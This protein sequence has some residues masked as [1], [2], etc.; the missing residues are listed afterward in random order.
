[1]ER[2]PW[3]ERLNEALAGQGL[4]VGVRSRFLE[5]L[6]DHLEDLTDGG[7]KMMSG[8]EV[9]LRMGAPEELA[10]RAALEHRRSSW[11]RRHPRLVFLAAPIPATLV[12]MAAYLLVAGLMAFGITEAGL[13][14]AD[15][16]SMWETP[17]SVFVASL[18]YV[19]FLIAAAAFARLSLVTQ[20]QRWCVIAS[21]GQIAALAGLVTAG[22]TWS[23]APGQ[24]Q[25]LLG[26]T[27]PFDGWVQATQLALPLSVG[28][29]AFVVATR[30]RRAAV[31]I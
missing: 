9:T 3:L 16:R 14:E 24:T 8:T 31:A 15:S 13:A 4:P 17:A 27:F 1:M 18:R 5:E 20:V 12:G 29:A 2:R 19:P 10:T 6:R 26:L 22:L 7:T 11:V 23:D 21:V 30:G 25:F 28:I